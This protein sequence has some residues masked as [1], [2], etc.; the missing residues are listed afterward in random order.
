MAKQAAI[1]VFAEF[2]A[3]DGTKEGAFKRLDELV[4]QLTQAEADVAEA[5]IDLKKAQGR[6]QKL[7]EFDI[8]DYMDELGLK[9]VTLNDS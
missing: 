4:K 8:P 1:D 9:C 3:D 5:Q 7:D 2:R 6:L